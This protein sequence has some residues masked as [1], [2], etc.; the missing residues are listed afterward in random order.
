MFDG[1]D[2]CAYDNNVDGDYYD[3]LDIAPGN[4]TLC[5]ECLCKGMYIVHASF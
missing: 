1:F 5:K 2:C 3:Y 4:T